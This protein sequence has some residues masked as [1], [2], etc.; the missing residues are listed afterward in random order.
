MTRERRIRKSSFS[1]IS[2]GKQLGKLLRRFV[3]FSKKKMCSNNKKEK[4]EQ[5]L[6]EILLSLIRK[7]TAFL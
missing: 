6:T 7:L 5:S 1:K 3:S 2:T 4:K